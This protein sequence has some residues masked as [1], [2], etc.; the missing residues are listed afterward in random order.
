LKINWNIKMYNLKNKCA[1]I[2]GS[3]RGIGKEIAI[4][5]AKNG[6]NIYLISRSINDLKVVKNEILSNYNVKVNAISLDIS[7]FED[8]NKTFE[9]IISKEGS[10][11]ILINN[12]G[13]TKDNLIMRMSSEDW[14]KVIDINLNGYFNCSKSIIKQMIKQKNG[15]IINISSIIGQKGNSGQSNYAA[16]KAGII[17]LTKSLAKEVGSRNINVNAIAPGYIETD[18]T[19]S[20][21][22]QSKQDFLNSIPLKRFGKTEEVANLVCFLCSNLSNYITGQVINIDGGLD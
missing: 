11:D 22:D 10:I 12:A 18:M 15:K 8:V 1:I 4:N 14:K 2:T 16:S 7:D 3:S 19:D 17:G 5:L 21:N 20:L 9:S 6:C 13:I